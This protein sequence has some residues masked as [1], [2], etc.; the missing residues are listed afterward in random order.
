ML[1]V[2]ITVLSP[3]LSLVIL[4]VGN[5]FFVTYVTV[6]L[7]L[8]GVP[9]WVIGAI[10]A[11]YYAGLVFG[12]FRIEPFIIRVGHIRA[13]AAFASLV[14][15]TIL[16]QALYINPWWWLILRL[17]SGYCMAGLFITI[18]SW[19]LVK[20]EKGTRG[21][22]LSLYMISF[23]AAQALGQF[24]LSAGDLKG[25]V[26]FILAAL[27]SSLSVVPLAMTRTAT[28]HF[29]EPSAL[30]FFQLYRISPVGIFGCFCS[31][32]I[33]GAIYGLLP[34]YISQ[35]QPETETIALLMGATIFGGMLL[36]YPVGKLSDALDRRKVIL[37]VVALVLALSILITTP[38]SHAL[39]I[40]LILLFFFGGLTFTIYPLSIS[41][42]LDYLQSKD[43]VAA[44]QGLL[45]AYSVGATFGPLL[46][47]GFMHLAGPR[48]LFFY[49]IAIGSLLTILVLWRSVTSPGVPKEEQQEFIPIPR[50]TPVGTELNPRQ[51]KSES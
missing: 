12:S 33:M 19:L 8:E 31:G 23:Y 17:I 1:S 44:T 29:E 16:L 2:L 49:F 25:I 4:T 21:Q 14:A 6:R 18:E 10:S 35:I 41:Y 42:A 46:G 36:Q 47:P 40:L 11:A 43:T 30:N 13:Y 9:A 26:P 39:F 32:L 5:G 37:G 24:L 45:L 34:L 20:S 27:L 15:T 7:H 38:L 51:P 3:L 50:T 22:V 28:P 48:G